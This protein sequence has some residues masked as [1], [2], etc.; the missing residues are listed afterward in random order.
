MHMHV[1][2]RCWCAVV[3]QLRLNISCSMLLLALCCKNIRS[4]AVFHLLQNNPDSA[5][6]Q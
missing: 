2:G 1:E 6:T 4:R 3:A 5:T